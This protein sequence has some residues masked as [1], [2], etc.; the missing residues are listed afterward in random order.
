[1]IDPTFIEMCAEA[2]EIQKAWVPQAGD[3][4][5]YSADSEFSEDIGMYI[6]NI[7]TG[8]RLRHRH[9]I[10][11]MGGIREPQKVFLQEVYVW[12]PRAGQLMR[13][14]EG[15]FDLK[16]VH[17]QYI[18]ICGNRGFV[19]NRTPEQALIRCIM[20]QK[21]GYSWTGEEWEAEA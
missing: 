13:M 12:L 19:Y 2:K 9:F 15:P 21:G 18:T 10:A 16:F 3:V 14:I 11:D 6:G 17:G 5:A 7:P 8:A 20:W 4:F 1:M